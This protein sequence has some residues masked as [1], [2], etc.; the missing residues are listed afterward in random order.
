MAVYE[1]RRWLQ[2]VGPEIRKCYFQAKFTKVTKTNDSIQAKQ[3]EAVE[4]I[5][6]NLGKKRQYPK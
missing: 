1:N 2:L 6:L 3:I 5:N 4:S